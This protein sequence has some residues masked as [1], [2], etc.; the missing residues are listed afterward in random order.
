AAT[1]SGSRTPARSDGRAPGMTY[2]QPVARALLPATASACALFS[3][4]A[5]HAAR[6]QTVVLV[7][8][9][10]ALEQAVRTSLAPW[11][12]NVEVVAS[13]HDAVQALA[14]AQEAGY[15]AWCEDGDLIFWDTAHGTRE[16]RAMAG[17]LGEADA[18]ALALSIKTW[19]RL[20]PPPSA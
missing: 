15:V 3:A 20:G 12:I 17:D 16:R 8:P 6:A 10:P 7:A 2:A 11:R 5:I 13:N 4:F 1:S 9:P 14:A 19:M 18:A